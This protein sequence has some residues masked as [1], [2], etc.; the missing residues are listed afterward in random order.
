[1]TQQPEQDSFDVIFDTQIESS[2]YG[3]GFWIVDISNI[4]KS[5]EK[6]HI[7]LTESP[8]EPVTPDPDQPPYQR[9]DLTVEQQ[10]QAMINNM[11]SAFNGE[12]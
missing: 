2:V 4:S 1:M 6:C 7:G 5:L 3:I 8:V 9:D 11:R 12:T 10:R